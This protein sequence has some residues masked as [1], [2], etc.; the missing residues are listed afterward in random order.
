MIK[1]KSFEKE[2]R[3]WNNYST[4]YK[5]LVE[6]AK[7]KELDFIATNVPRRYASIVHKKGFEGLNELSLDAK[8]FIAPLPVAYDPE[9]KGYQAMLEMMGGMGGDHV[10]E[11]LPK[12]QAIKD[13]TMAYFILQNWEAGKTFIHYNGTYHSNDY[14]GI[15]WYL[16]EANPTLKIVT[17]ASVEQDDITKLEKESK[18]V[19][20]YILC[21]PSNMT[22]TY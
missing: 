13:A 11:N 3:L 21:I 19:A 6:F 4:D 7:E 14:E 20:D 1:Q 5:P 10:N 16:K 22:K 12:A 15:M 17:I 18:N 9:L 2:A 8:K